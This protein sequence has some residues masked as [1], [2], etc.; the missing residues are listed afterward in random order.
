M[1][2]CTTGLPKGVILA[3]GNAWWNA[4]NVD[5]VVDT[6]RGDVTHAA[7]PLFH[8]G[9]LN[10]FAVR[11]LVRGVVDPISRKPVPAGERGE[12]IEI[13]QTGPRNA[14]GKPDKVGVRRLVS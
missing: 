4:V 11:N 5:S 1:T 13:V 10:S 3:H 14:S 2:L 12:V 6:R 7:A 8:I 9:A